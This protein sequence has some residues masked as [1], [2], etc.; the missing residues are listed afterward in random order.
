MCQLSE[1]AFGKRDVV[2]AASS[3]QTLK[4]AAHTSCLLKPP[5]PPPVASAPLG[6]GGP[7]FS[8]SQLCKCAPMLGKQRQLRPGLKEFSKPAVG[9]RHKSDTE[10]SM[11]AVLRGVRAGL[12]RAGFRGRGCSRLSLKRRRD[13]G[14]RLGGFGAARGRK[15]R[16]RKQPGSGGT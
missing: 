15:V 8:H 16:A 11:T 7:R 9:M 2:A 6:L 10:Q 13:S 4:E 1:F 3:V 5:P 12:V 14:F